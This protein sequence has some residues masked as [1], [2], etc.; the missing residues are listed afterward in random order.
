MLV[1]WFGLVWSGSVWL[2]L[3]YKNH[4]LKV[5]GFEPVATALKG[6]RSTG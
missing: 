3:V 6:L 1:V 4:Y 2:D 5:T